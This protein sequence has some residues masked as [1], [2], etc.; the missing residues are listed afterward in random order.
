[1]KKLHNEKLHDGCNSPNIIWMLTARRMRGAEH[2]ACM[3]EKRNACSILIMEHGRKRPLGT[4][5]HEWEDD[6]IRDRREI[7]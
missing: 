4:P 2:V 6:I 3:E 5:R 7:G 1:M